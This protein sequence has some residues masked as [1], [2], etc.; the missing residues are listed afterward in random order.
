[1]KG[2][3]FRDIRQNWLLTTDRNEEDIKKLRK[4]FLW[5][6][7][8]PDYIQNDLRSKQENVID[9]MQHFCLERDIQLVIIDV[10]EKTNT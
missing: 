10:Y 3:P 2:R 9:R 8:I 4:R 1:M 7:M 5:L 6:E